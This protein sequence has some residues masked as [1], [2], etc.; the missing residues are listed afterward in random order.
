MFDDNICDTLMFDEMVQ[1]IYMFVAVAISCGKT[2]QKAAGSN[3]PGR[4]F[5]AGYLQNIR[6]LKTA[7][8]FLAMIP[9][10]GAGFLAGIS[11]WPDFPGGPDYPA[12]T[13]TG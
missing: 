9:W 7:K 3:S 10:I 11:R 2:S 4:I 1:I 6:P 5:R 13:Y 12:L 8:D